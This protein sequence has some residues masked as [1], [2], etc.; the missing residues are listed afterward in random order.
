MDSLDME[1]VKFEGIVPSP[2]LVSLDDNFH[3]YS[4]LKQNGFSRESAMRQLFAR[5]KGTSIG[6]QIMDSRKASLDRLLQAFRNQLSQVPAQSFVGNLQPNEN[7]CVSA[8][9]PRRNNKVVLFVDSEDTVAQAIAVVY[10]KQIAS[11]PVYDRGKKEFLGFF[12]L[13]NLLP[14]VQQTFEHSRH[15]SGTDWTTGLHT[16]SPALSSLVGALEADW[17]VGSFV[18]TYSP[19]DSQSDSILQEP[20]SA[21][22]L[23]SRLSDSGRVL[24]CSGRLPRTVVSQHNLLSALGP[25]LRKRPLADICSRSIDDLGLCNGNALC[26][27]TESDSIISAIS[28]LSKLEV[29][30]QSEFELERLSF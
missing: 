3:S 19:P 26:V 17:S 6:G 28:R 29:N 12:T 24:L 15:G 13:S 27:V 30:K 25:W 22:T 11:V 21:L 10:E 2:N 23:A 7:V 16:R 8:K 1:V 14:G 20:C 5:A 18:Q 9:S 4:R